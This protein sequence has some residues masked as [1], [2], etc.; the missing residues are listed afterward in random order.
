[1]ADNENPIE[2]IPEITFEVEVSETVP[3]PVDSTLT[4]SGQAA[5]SVR[6]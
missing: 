5:D 4:V 1:M 3:A 2:G 6:G